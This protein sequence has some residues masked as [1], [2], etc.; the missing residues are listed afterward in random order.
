MYLADIIGTNS[1][2]TGK[3]CWYILYFNTGQRGGRVKEENAH[4]NPWKGRVC[5]LIGWKRFSMTQQLR[6]WRRSS[7]LSRDWGYLLLIHEIINQ[8]GA[9]FF[10]FFKKATVS[11]TNWNRGD[12]L[13]CTFGKDSVK[14]FSCTYV[15]NEEV[16]PTPGISEILDKAV[17]HPFQQHLQDEDVGEHSVGVFQNDTDGLPLLD[18]HVLKGLERRER[19]CSASH[20]QN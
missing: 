14:A 3:V 9:F 13:L 20:G 16:Q 4:R 2:K 15:H 11:L 17:G 10:F 19:W 6:A 1:A 5:V 18:I 12:K 7:E 8:V